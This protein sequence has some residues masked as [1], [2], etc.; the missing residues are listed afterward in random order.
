MMSFLFTKEMPN[1]LFLLLANAAISSTL[2]QQ[3]LA[4]L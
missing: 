3:Q 4:S 1:L 2:Y